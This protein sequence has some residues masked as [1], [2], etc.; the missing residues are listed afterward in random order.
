MPRINI[1]SGVLFWGSLDI[2]LGTLCGDT[3][4]GPHKKIAS[5]SAEE[6]DG[7]GGVQ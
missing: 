2:S 1:V 3:Y 4:A 7:K 5:Q 6:L